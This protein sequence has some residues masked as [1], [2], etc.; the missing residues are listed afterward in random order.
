M[1]MKLR[2]IAPVIVHETLKKNTKEYY[3]ILLTLFINQIYQL[4]HYL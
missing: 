4:K 2:V 1:Q 3:F